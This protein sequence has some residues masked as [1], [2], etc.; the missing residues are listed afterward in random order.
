MAIHAG[1]TKR[2]EESGINGIHILIKPGRKYR[3]VLAGVRSQKTTDFDDPYVAAQAVIDGFRPT[4]GKKQEKQV[5]EKTAMR[6]I[7][8]M[9]SPLQHEWLASQPKSMTSVIRDLIEKYR[10]SRKNPPEERSPSEVMQTQVY[11]DSEQY[12]WL[13]KAGVTMAGVVRG[14]IQSEI[15]PSAVNAKKVTSPISNKTVQVYDKIVTRITIE[16][17]RWLFFNHEGHLSHAVSALIDSAM[18]RNPMLPLPS[19]DGEMVRI[20]LYPTEEQKA[21]LAEKSANV[22]LAYVVRSVI[23]EAMERETRKGVPVA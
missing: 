16:Q 17:Q 8:I 20:T 2:I 7:Q 18:E 6:P 14:M 13:K 1:A 22:P 5:A 9:L 3:P 11:L 21:W 15:D 4:K 10:Q 19:S 23:Q 12:A